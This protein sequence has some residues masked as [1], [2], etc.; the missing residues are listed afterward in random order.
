MELTHEEKLAVGAGRKEIFDDT[1][2][3]LNRMK[4]AIKKSLEK[5]AIKVSSMKE[6]IMTETLH[7]KRLQGKLQRIDEIILKVKE[8]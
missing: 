4:D 5:Q 3:D 6:E 2:R 1:M 8:I 7:M